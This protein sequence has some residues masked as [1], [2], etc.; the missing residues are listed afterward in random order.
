[1]TE[2]QSSHPASEAVKDSS[3]DFFAIP[4]TNI[5]YNSYRIRDVNP[6]SRSI[7]PVEFQIE[8]SMDYTDLSRSFFSFKIRLQ[9]GAGADLDAAHDIFPAPNLMHTMIQQPSIWVNGVLITEQTDTYAYKAYLETILNYSQEDTK[10]FL[11]NAGFYPA[12]DFPPAVTA[13]ILNIG[14]NGGLGHDDLQGLSSEAQAAVRRGLA[15]RAHCA[16]GNEVI[17]TGRL[18]ADIFNINKLLVPGVHLRIKLDL[19]KPNFFMI[20]QGA[21]ANVRL[22]QEDLKVTFHMCHVKVRHDLYNT[23]VQDRLKNRKVVMYP[24]VRSEI[25]VF[26]IPTGQQVFEETDIFK[27][28]IPNRVV[29]GMVHSD[30]YHGNY[31]RNP[32][33]FEKFGATKVSQIVRGEE[34]PYQITEMN[35]NNDQLDGYIYN[36]LIE[37]SCARF[38]HGFMIQPEHWGQDKTTTLFMFDNVASGCG[39]RLDM[40]NPKQA[41]DV[42]IKILFGAA[43]THVINVIIYGEFENFMHIDPNGAVLYNIY[44][45]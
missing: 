9:T 20:G 1:M 16:G 4:P 45:S 42:K 14:A 30:A 34:Y 7:N 15:L 38:K 22:T 32:F 18:F 11:K 25:R 8:P 41:G 24:T 39:D 28:R 13:N 17:L 5:Q 35:H 19:N 12:L 44:Q 29:V 27:G 6:T 2:A 33:C 26:S 3:S 40:L 21:N 31:T 23:V 43:T 10:T 37:A 36:Q